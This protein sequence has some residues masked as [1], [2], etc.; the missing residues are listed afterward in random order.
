[1]LA[2]LL[3]RAESRPFELNR[4]RLDS[5]GMVPVLERLLRGGGGGRDRIKAVKPLYKAVNF[6]GIQCVIGDKECLGR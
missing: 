6:F 3:R 1:M 4:R 2:T 5:L